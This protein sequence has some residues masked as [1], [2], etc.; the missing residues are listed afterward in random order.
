MGLREGGEGGIKGEVAEAS[1]QPSRRALMSSRW[2]LSLLRMIRQGKIMHIGHAP[3]PSSG[4]VWVHAGCTQG[5]VGCGRRQNVT[6][7]EGA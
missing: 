4:W 7:W 2:L 5:E 3:M 6:G 1:G